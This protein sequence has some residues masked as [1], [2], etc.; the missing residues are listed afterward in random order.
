MHQLVFHFCLLPST[1]TYIYKNTR[2]LCTYQLV[3]LSFSYFVF[4]F[5]FIFIYRSLD[6]IVGARRV[7]VTKSKLHIHGDLH[8]VNKILNSNYKTKKN[9]H[10]VYT[11]RTKTPCVWIKYSFSDLKSIDTPT[12][13]H[14]PRHD[15]IRLINYN[16]PNVCIINGNKAFKILFQLNIWLRYIIMT[17][18]WA[19]P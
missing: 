3:I 8:N 5:N 4:Y 15:V 1:R 10:T 18:A 11:P 9:T 2:Y 6:F 16:I 19:I 14:K 17:R 7:S 12:I 13:T